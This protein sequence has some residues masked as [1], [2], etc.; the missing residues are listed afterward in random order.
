MTNE[1][2]KQLQALLNGEVFDPL[3]AAFI[4]DSPWLPNWAGMTL[5]DY[6]AS[7]TNWLKANL[8]AL[9]TFPDIWFLPGFWSEYGMCTEPSAFGAKC[10]WQENE[11]PFAEKVSDDIDRLASLPVPNPRSDGLVPFILARL[12][13]LEPAIVEANHAIRFAVARGPL[14][15]AG[16][17]MGNTEFLMAMRMEPDKTHALLQ[18]ITTFLVDWIQL[19]AQTFASIDG[20]L[21]LDDLVGFCSKE[22]FTTFAKPYLKQTFEAIDGSVR[23]FH[24][25]AYGYVCAP[26]LAEIGINLFN[27]SHEHPINEMRSHVGDQVTLLGNIPPRDVMAQGTPN[28]VRDAVIQLLADIEDPKRILLSCGGGM[29]P[30]VPTENINAFLSGIH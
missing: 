23:F 9:H 18:T 16:F 20:I 5:M 25:D 29:A 22:D 21:L 14:N 4:I 26:H 17:L 8:Q 7:E 15:I 10:I 12:R 6:Y 1:Q 19:Q 13:H 27:F 30:G 28:N 24:N 11:F 2:W 3:P